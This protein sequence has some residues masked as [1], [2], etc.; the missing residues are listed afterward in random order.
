M[1]LIDSERWR[2]LEPLLDEGFELAPEERARWLSEMR[3][4]DPEIAAEIASLLDHDDEAERS[5]FLE[6]PMNV[7][8]AGL[9]LGGWT[10]EGPLGHGGMGSVW[11]ARRS[12]GRYEGTAAVKLLNLALV[13]E[14]G[15]A[16]FRREGSALGRL[17]HPSV[18]R[19][20]DAGVTPGG[21][22]FLVLEH[23][24]GTRIDGWVRDHRLTTRQCVQLFLQVLDAVGHAHT[25]LVV[26]RDLKPT[27]ILVTADGRVKLLDFG[28]AKLL[29][30]DE[31]ERDGSPVTDGWRALTPEY[32]APEQVAAGPV[33]TATDI[34]AA[35]VLLYVLLSGRHPTAESCHTATEILASV[36]K[37]PANPLGLGDLDNVLAK[38]LSKDPRDRY[39][40][41]AEFAEDVRR[42]LDHKP[43]RA[44]ANSWRYRS[45]KF[46]QRNRGSALLVVAGFLLSGIWLGTIVNDRSRLRVAL[47]QA[48]NNAER[49]ELVTDF[50]VGLFESSGRG[51]AYADSVSVRQLMEEATK[52][53]S[54]LKGQ[55]V[56]QAQM[57]DLVGRIRQQMGDQSGARPLLEEALAIRRRVLG[58]SD[59]DVATTMIT[60]GEAIG[61][62]DHNDTASVRML[63]QALEIR[64][65]QFGNDDPRTIDALYALATNMH[66]AGDFKAAKPVMDEWM[67]AVQRVPMQITPDHAQQLHQMA[68]VL[69]YSRRLPEAEALSRRAMS[70]DSAWY[71]AGHS[72][73]AIDMSNLGEVVEDL[74]RLDEAEHL[75]RTAIAVL[76]RAYPDGDLA[77]ARALRL[78]GFLLNN[79]GRY[80]EAEGIW[81]K[82]IPMYIRFP[83]VGGANR[84]IA[85]AQLGK[86]LIGQERYAAADSVLNDALT[87]ESI[88]RPGPNQVRDGI[89][90]YRGVI[91]TSR[92]RF[93]EAEP[94][95]KAAFAAK[96]FIAV[97]AS[98]K[99]MAAR[100]LVTIYEAEAR[101]AE[102]AE[103]K[104]W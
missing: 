27:N 88:K 5:G 62:V 89:G 11:L 74:G 100:A 54:E 87:L 25:H 91:L 70:M 32:A 95:L 99:H 66:Q 83:E 101:S 43:V 35:G 14:P 65:Q 31:T 76:E 20:L 4:R 53:T 47:T 93:R 77:N 68:D 24:E 90:I 92:G 46:L 86:A 39:S 15:Q 37:R 84:A 49:A 34:Y 103:Y 9:E 85:A 30:D 7:T 33:T 50:A 102:A 57:L 18:A 8:L 64:R 80:A 96:R 1:A 75:E 79:E 13:S 63:R 28:I 44:R 56:I 6:R 45:A 23:V 16:R 98:D 82:A 10:L 104:R 19:L 26:H 59:P 41:A 73:V 36:I 55:P 40:T 21:Q 94:M 17:A 71:G 3:T 60:L 72:R 48:T 42:W 51:P 58:A 67:A 52:R 38:A 12:D 2:E 69:M 61:K 29:D 22:P 81:R 97:N 78:L